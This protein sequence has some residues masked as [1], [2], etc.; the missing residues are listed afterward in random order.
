[1]NQALETSASGI[2][3]P[4]QT[5]LRLQGITK[6]FPGVKALDNVDFDLFSSEVHV[7]L[8]ENGAGKSTLM[9]ILAGV[10]TAGSGRVVLRGAPVRIQSPRQAREHGISIIYQEFNL[11]PELTV[12]QNIFLGR[13]PRTSLG[14]VDQ[15][16]LVA[17]ARRF[18]E[19]L[20]ADIDV[21]TK[22]KSLGVAQ[23]QLVEVAKALSLEARI[24]IMDE[25]T[26]TLSEREIERLFATIRVLKQNGV[27]IIYISHRL[28][29]IRQIGDRVTVLRDGRTV[30]TR[31]IADTN[32]DALIQMMVGRTVS[33][34]RIRVRNTARPGE[35]LRVKSLS[36]GGT[37]KKIDLVV[38][39]GEIVALA[40]LVG[41]GR[42]ELARAIFGI[43]SPDAGTIS[44]MGRPLARPSPVACI[45]GGMGFLPE[46]RKEDGLALILPVK[47]NIVQASLRKL[48]PLGVLNHRLERATAQKYVQDLSMACPSVSRMTKFLSGGTQQK[49]VLA[50]WLCTESKFLV[51]DEPTRGIDV[52]AKEEIHVLI[53]G[54]AGQGVGILM[55]SSELPEILSL[56]DRV[57]VMREGAIIAE[58]ITERTTQEEIIAYAAGGR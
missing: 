50:K 48:F 13:E 18:L 4:Q 56:S 17:E 29:E 3:T 21:S 10:Y 25:P 55:I 7:L 6:Q 33:Q 11:I 41:S 1:M 20:K 58:L 42:T 22:V 54:L 39:E 43:D 12:A 5:I 9:K 49:V 8:G 31:S 47:D 2:T 16:A 40:G 23:Q 15:K 57:Y 36:R 46:N 30:G 14:L 34:R 26:A 45:A 35:A 53:N 51:F 44:M 38:H 27:S 52:G 19:V 24:L 37:L 28:Q 32:L